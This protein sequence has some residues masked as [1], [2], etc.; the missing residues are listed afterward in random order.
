[1]WHSFSYIHLS[2]SLVVLP[3]LNNFEDIYNP[4]SLA[5]V[6]VSVYKTPRSFLQVSFLIFL[7]FDTS[8]WLA[9]PTP[10][11]LIRSR[12]LK[13]HASWKHHSKSIRFA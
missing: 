7:Q 4:S 5:P 9:Q 8:N 12:W 3:I 6:F 13:S 1:M 2:L 11:Q 10:K